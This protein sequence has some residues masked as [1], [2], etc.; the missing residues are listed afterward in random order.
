MYYHAISG[1]S[2]IKI[3]VRGPHARTKLHMSHTFLP[4]NNKNTIGRWKQYEKDQKA[5]NDQCLQN[6]VHNIWI[7][8]FQKKKFVSKFHSH[9]YICSSLAESLATNFI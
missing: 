2:F 1:V 7:Q 6:R 4:N 9:P 3:T 8:Y 5:F